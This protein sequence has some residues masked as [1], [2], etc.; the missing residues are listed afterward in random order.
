MATK[1]VEKPE[2][3]QRKVYLELDADARADGL[4]PVN[5]FLSFAIVASVATAILETEISLSSG[6]EV[7]FRTAEIFFGVTFLIEYLTRLWIAP[8]RFPELSPVMARLKWALSPLS[9]IDLL[10]LLPLL[11]V[12]QAAPTVVIRLVR[13]LRVLRLAKL[14]RM[15]KAFDLVME[16]FASRRYELGVTGGIGIVLLI[17]TSTVLYLVEG[18]IQP[19]AFGSIPRALWWGVITLTTIGY[20]DVY[21]VTP[22]GKIFAGVTAVIG[23][24]LVAAPTGI[25]AAGFAEE[26]REKSASKTKTK[27][28]T[29]TGS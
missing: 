3:L 12:A 10:A 18:H 2:T 1:A 15:S 8:L 14:G 11:F 21:P 9:L 24:G 26:L 27:T 16:T 4:S 6:R 13:L 28:E 7:Y 5:V 29:K 20:G 17:A 19:E 25:L 23:I 22:L